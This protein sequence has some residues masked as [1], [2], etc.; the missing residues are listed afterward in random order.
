[1]WLTQRVGGE[2]GGD[3][4]ATL[5]SERESREKRRLWKARTGVAYDV[6]DMED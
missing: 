2:R 3:D 4:D 5:Q 6:E 1:M